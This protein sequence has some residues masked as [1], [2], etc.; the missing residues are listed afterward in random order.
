M[1]VTY[2]LYRRKNG[3]YYAQHNE[4]GRQISLRTSDE[5]TAKLL[6]QGHNEGSRDAQVSR[7]VGLAY[8]S[9]TDPEAKKR[10]LSS[11]F[12]CMPSARFICSLS[13]HMRTSSRCN[14]VVSLCTNGLSLAMWLRKA[15]NLNSSGMDLM[16]AESD[17]NSKEFEICVIGDRMKDEGR[18]SSLAKNDGICVSH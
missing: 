6:L 12:A 15:S 10:S 2:R 11:N 18:F 8:L 1:N 9:C 7:E 14:R 3:K 17:P 5:N 13:S 4:T 16:V